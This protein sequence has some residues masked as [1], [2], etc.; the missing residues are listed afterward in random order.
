MTS[1][2]SERA[3]AFPAWWATRTARERMLLAVLAALTLAI[4]LWYGLVTPIL[5]AE[6]AARERH[7]RAV[8]RLLA[9]SASA[10][11]VAALQGPAFRSSSGGGLAATVTQ[12]ALANAVPLAQQTSAPNADLAITVTAADPGSAFRWLASLQR[13]HGV[14][15]AAWVMTRN[16][17]RSVALQVRFS[18]GMT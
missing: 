14:H 1:L 9:V 12:T 8:E 3:A 17:D 10:R 2:A 11:E 7:A 13:D 15:V 6:S 18:K 4:G 5:S 16:P